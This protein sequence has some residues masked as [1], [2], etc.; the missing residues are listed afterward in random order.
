[1]YYIE[2]G[3]H[4]V[5]FNPNHIT[6][7]DDTF[8]FECDTIVAPNIFQLFLYIKVIRNADGVIIISF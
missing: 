5:F 8:G 4:A 1:M 2:C 3:T 6:F 7:D